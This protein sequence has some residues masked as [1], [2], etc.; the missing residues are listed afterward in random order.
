MPT[1]KR[2]NLGGPRNKGKYRGQKNKDTVIASADNIDLNTED[3][4]P[5]LATTE[6]LDD[7]ATTPRTSS[8]DLNPSIPTPSSPTTPSDSTTNIST[9]TVSFAPGNEWMGFYN[10]PPNVAMSNQAVKCA[11]T[12]C[13]MQNSNL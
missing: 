7:N 11:K 10:V 4:N 9:P 2:I 3:I 1:R 8:N 12:W 13:T 5:S 6:P